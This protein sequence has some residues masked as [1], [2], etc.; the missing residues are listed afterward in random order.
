MFLIIMKREMHQP[1]ALMH[2]IIIAHFRLLNY[3]D[4]AFL[5]LFKRVITK[6]I[7]IIFIIKTFSSKL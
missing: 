5:C 2:L 1:N 6:K 7:I 4:L 3:I